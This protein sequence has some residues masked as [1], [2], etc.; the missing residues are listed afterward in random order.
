MMRKLSLVLGILLLFT[1]LVLTFQKPIMVLLVDNMSKET[2]QK[3]NIEKAKTTPQATF[4]FAK[5][6][7]IR[8]QDVLDA[9]TKKKDVHAIGAISVPD[10]HMQLPIVY[11]IS[12][13]NL[14]VGAGTMKQD[15][16]MG[17]GNYSL[18]GHNM[19]N[20]KTLFSPLTKAQEGMKVYITDFRNIYEYQ[21][22]DMFIV[23][24]T[25]V[26]VIQDQ[27]DEKLITLVTCN[28]NGE[29][30]M[31]IRGKLIKK[32]TYTDDTSYFKLK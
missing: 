14:T 11:G 22:S 32:E 9:Q 16:V 23:K 28:Y 24:P 30:R 25:Q 18:A 3:T 6:E 12:N 19:N 2:I 8:L 10:V 17:Q 26:E 27:G 15:Q 20:G 5:V 21:I 7:N 1:G 31:I 29:K 4:D 13:I